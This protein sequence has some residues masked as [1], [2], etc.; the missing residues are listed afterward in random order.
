MTID[1]KYRYIL[2]FSNE[3]FLFFFFVLLLLDFAFHFCSIK[4]L[5]SC[6]GA[7]FHILYYITLVH[8]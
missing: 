1:K 2:P 7:F 5:W 6:V 8:I 4:F 3:A